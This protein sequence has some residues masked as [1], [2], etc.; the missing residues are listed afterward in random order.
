M[1]NKFS[2]DLALDGCHSKHAVVNLRAMFIRLALSAAL[3]ATSVTAALTAPS[4]IIILRHG[5]QA[6]AWRLCGVGQQ[7]A[8]ALKYNYLGKDAA[9]SLFTEDAPCLL[10]CNYGPYYG[11]RYACG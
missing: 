9:K 4:R 7:R 5:E 8:Q 3:L 11:T 6:D 10:L 2:N 1:S